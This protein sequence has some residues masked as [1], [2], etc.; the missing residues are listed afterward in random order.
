M[1]KAKMAGLTDKVS[2]KTMP[3]MVWVFPLV[4]ALLILGS[5]FTILIPQVSGIIEGRG[6]VETLKKQHEQL[7]AKRTSLENLSEAEL[8]QQFE[9]AEFVLPSSKPLFRFMQSMGGLIQQHETV[10]M[11][12][13]ELSPGSLATESG[14]VVES[15]GKLSRLATELTLQG[16]FNEVYKLL[17]DYYSLSPF[18]SVQNIQF[19]GDIAGA[20]DSVSNSEISASLTLNIYYSPPLE[21]LGRVSDPLPRLTTSI[22]ETYLLLD[23]FTDYGNQVEIIPSLD[24]QRQNPFAF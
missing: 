11:S 16:N 22:A 18:V 17:G 20:I 21:V 5:L 10:R 1:A 23:A 7:V 14:E 2:I 13:Y 8:R 19:S 4:T 24:Q 15:A 12:D 6:Q 9:K 3:T